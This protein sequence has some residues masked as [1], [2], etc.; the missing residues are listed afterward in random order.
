MRKKNN[1]LDKRTKLV[2]LLL[3]VCGQDM[4]RS[5]PTAAPTPPSVWWSL[6]PGT[7]PSDSGTSETRPSIL[8]TSSRDTQSE[9]VQYRVHSDGWL[10]QSYF[11][12][13]GGAVTSL[14]SVNPS[15]S[16]CIFP[17]SFSSV[18]LIYRPFCSKPNPPLV[19]HSLQNTSPHISLCLLS[20]ASLA[21][22]LSLA[23]SC[24]FICPFLR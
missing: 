5:W 23:L 9:S 19:S 6:H 13:Q 22:S 11:G 20:F 12:P 1:C 18:T 17:F 7:P 8:S 15:S 21:L 3:C 14:W 2:W 16:S 4:I 10:Q 24:S